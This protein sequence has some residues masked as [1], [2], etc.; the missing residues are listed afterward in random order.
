MRSKMYLLLMLIPL[1]LVIYSCAAY[2]Y[3]TPYRG[4]N[5]EQ[6]EATVVQKGWDCFTCHKVEVAQSFWDEPD[7]QKRAEV[8]RKMLEQI[9]NKEFVEDRCHW[10]HIEI[11][12]RVAEATP[13]C[14]ACH[15]N[16]H[17]VKPDTHNGTWIYAHTASA[18][19][20]GYNGVYRVRETTTMYTCESCHNEWYCVDC[21]TARDR[22]RSWMHNRNFRI[23]HVAAAVSDPG[24]CGSCHTTRY[25]ID[26]HGGGGRQ[27][28]I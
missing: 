16:L 27:G 14:A 11:N 20:N 17:Q 2:R 15:D 13:S 4:F 25:C 18:L 6:H 1:V 5:H 21:H 10:C 12:T 8:L 24:L 28:R 3:I 22:E 19:E 26:C 23:S 7:P 9:Q